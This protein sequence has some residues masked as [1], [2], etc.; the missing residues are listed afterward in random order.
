MEG[1]KTWEAV[2]NF[3]LL[4]QSVEYSRYM[5]YANDPNAITL[6]DD[7]LSYI[8]GTTIWIPTFNPSTKNEQ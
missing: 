4:D 5:D 7:I 2:R 1:D 6:H 3:I 8:W